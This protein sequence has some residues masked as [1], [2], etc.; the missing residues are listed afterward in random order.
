M[1]VKQKAINNF[2]LG[3]V[4]HLKTEGKLTCYRGTKRSTGRALYFTPAAYHHSVATE[5]LS[6]DSR[7]LSVLRA[8]PTA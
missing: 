8:N 2:S 7:L 5:M 1:Q 4:N 6:L 3:N